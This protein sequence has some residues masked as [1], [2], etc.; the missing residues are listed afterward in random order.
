MDGVTLVSGTIDHNY[1][2]YLVYMIYAGTKYSRHTYHL[3]VREMLDL[4]PDLYGY[5]AT[6]II[7]W[8]GCYTKTIQM[9]STQGVHV[10]IPQFTLAHSTI[11]INE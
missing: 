8:E 6:I 10:V 4:V 9:L 3:T 5:S 7:L 1:I 2:D 11:D